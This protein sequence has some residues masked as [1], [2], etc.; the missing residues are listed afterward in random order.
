MKRNGIMM[1]WSLF[2][3]LFLLSGCATMETSQKPYEVTPKRTVIYGGEFEFALPPSGWNIFW[4]EG[5]GSGEFAFGFIK[6]DP[7]GF[8][9]QSVFAYDEDPFGTSTELDVREKEFL[10]RFLWNAILTFETLE[11]KKVQVLGGEGLEVLVEGKN[12]IAKEKAKAKIIFGKRGDRVIAFYITQW[13]PMDGTYDPS[14]FE[15]FDK[16]VNSFK[17]LRKSFYETL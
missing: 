9:S 5:A 2:I 11:K 14:A 6:S 13:R 15:I 16:F 12:S 1:L 3:V 17:F 7:G 4:P 8:P 10:K